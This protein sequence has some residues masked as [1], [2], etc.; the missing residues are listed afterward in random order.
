MVVGG[1]SPLVLLAG[2]CVLESEAVVMT[3]AEALAELGDELG[4]PIIF[5][6]SFDKANRSSVS[7]FRGPGLEQGLRWLEQVPLPTTTDV[8]LPGQAAAVA[9]V[10]DLL[11]VPA[12][13]CRQTDLLQACAAT[14]KPV[15]VKKGQ[16]MAPQQM[17][18]V[19]TKLE[20]PAMLTERGTTFGYGDLVADLRALPRMRALGVPVCFDCTHAVQRPGALRSEGDRELAPGLA[21]AAVA[22]GVD[23]LFMEVH[24]SPEHGLSDAST[25]LPLS[26]LRELLSTVMEIDALLK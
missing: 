14:G 23:A 25:M 12:F 26:G 16:F 6:G 2:P 15:N 8:H 13:L 3:I 21:R 4:L 5:K 9:E 19:L 22:M 20:G 24:P 17:A 7:S 10:V 1:G 18:G 11:Q